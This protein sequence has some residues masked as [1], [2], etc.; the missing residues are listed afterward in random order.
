MRVTFLGT[1]AAGGVPLWGCTCAACERAL[2]D[3]RHARQPCS[4]L[5]ECGTSRVL[6]D[7]GIMDLH[8]RFASGSLAAIALTHFHPDHVQGLFHLRWGC[9]DTIAVYAPPDVEGCADLYKHPGVLSFRTLEAFR[10]Q[11]IGALCLVPLPLAHS[12]PTFGYAVEVDGG[13]RF[14]YLTDT[15]GLPPA[16]EAFLKAWRAD[17]LAIDCTYPPGH[18]AASGHNDWLNALKSI[19]DVK[20][21]RAWL[22]HVGHALDEWLIDAHLVTPEHVTVACDGECVTIGRGGAP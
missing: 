22:T 19:A 21:A 5:I 8:R 12:K 6:I 15:R 11:R 17:G 1:G 10:P 2:A 14:A 4:A 13:A 16:T 9:G 3:A 18:F 7:A 20:P